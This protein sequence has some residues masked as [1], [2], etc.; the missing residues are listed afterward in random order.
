MTDDE[1][2]ICQME[3]HPTL[4]KLRRERAEIFK[5]WQAI[6]GPNAFQNCQQQYMGQLMPW[7][8][9]LAGIGSKGAGGQP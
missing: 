1:R 4:I 3:V 2:T 6:Y 7:T 5:K 9:W 8:S